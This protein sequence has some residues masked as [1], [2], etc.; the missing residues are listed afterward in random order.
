[1]RVFTDLL[2]GVLV[3]GDPEAAEAL[4]TLEREVSDHARH[5][6]LVALAS[7]LHVV[8]RRDADG[9]PGGVGGAD[10]D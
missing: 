5:P 1:V 6:D 10:P 7:H 4:L 2:P 8:V 3:D 9:D